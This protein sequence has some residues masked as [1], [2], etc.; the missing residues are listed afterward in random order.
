MTEQLTDIIDAA[1]ENPSLWQILT[2]HRAVF[3]YVVVLL[4]A[5][6]LL[7]LLFIIRNAKDTALKEREK[8]QKQLK[9]RFSRLSALDDEETGDRGEFDNDISLSE[10]CEKF[11]DFA[12]SRMG[13]YYDID[14]VRA[15]VASL[16]VTKLIIMQGI[17]GTGK[18]SLAYAFG[19]FLEHDASIVPVQP[20]W[21]DRTD[22]LGYYNEFTGNF[23]ETE[24]LYN[25]Y[26]A[27]GNDKIYLTVL[28][29]MNIARV[30]YY[31]AEFLSVLE[32]PELASRKIEVVSDI[33]ENDPKRLEEGKLTVPDNMWFVGT[34]NNDD[35]TLSISDKVYDRAMVIELQSRAK[36]FT[37]P[38]TEPV[39]VSAPYL[40]TLYNRAYHEYAMTD[41]IRIKTE[42]LDKY[43]SKH[44]QITFG[45]RILRQ[46]EK[47]IPVYRACGGTEAEAVDLILSKKVLR[48]LEAQ[49]PV[50]V[51]A[52]AEGVISAI[53]RIF[54]EGELP[55][56][57]SYM[58]K[59][60]KI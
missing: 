8:K 11:R 15:F 31:F 32:L 51:A 28:D 42:E 20:S 21:K 5:L 57:V 46:T 58:R 60:V 44:L 40:F 23:T 24:L 29:E 39:S 6:I 22:M 14:V 12:S 45:N 34:A 55:A 7:M 10:L 1:E 25:L 26:E 38:D 27:N 30:E 53:E 41:D 50:Y 35:S 37:A 47:F 17:S 9:R 43:L 16:S 52:E 4:S 54:G 3:A 2:G 56:C 59:F 13:L 36:P 33:R 49:N 18:T 48:K 19:K